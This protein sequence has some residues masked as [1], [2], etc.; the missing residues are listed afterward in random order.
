MKL[1]L[2]IISKNYKYNF[3]NKYYITTN[4]GIITINI[5]HK[6]YLYY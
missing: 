2:K 5:I 1:F 4:I 6:C 3:I